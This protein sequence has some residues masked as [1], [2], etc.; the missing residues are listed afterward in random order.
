MKLWV[1]RLPLFVGEPMVIIEAYAG[2]S[3]SAPYHNR[4]NLRVR[5]GGRDVFPLN[6]LWVW[7]PARHDTDSDRARALA[8]DA[9]ALGIE[10]TSDYSASQLAFVARHADALVCARLDRYGDL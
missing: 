6:Q 2:D 3:S 1:L 7:L 8:I 4:L 10:G 9:V 5:H